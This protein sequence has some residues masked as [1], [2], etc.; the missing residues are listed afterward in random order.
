MWFIFI[1][2]KQLRCVSCQLVKL[3]SC[4]FVHIDK[5]FDFWIYWLV[6]SKDFFSPLLFSITL[7]V[8]YKLTATPWTYYWW[9]V[10]SFLNFTKNQT[11]SFRFIRELQKAEPLPSIIFLWIINVVSNTVNSQYKTKMK[12]ETLFNT[13]SN[14]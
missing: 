11:K 10:Y 14:Q 6:F 13:L 2:F 4:L 12:K 7:R 1:F 9:D 8:I 5:L 3:R